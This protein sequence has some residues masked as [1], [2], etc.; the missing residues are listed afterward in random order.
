MWRWIRSDCWDLPS[1]VSAPCC[2][3][4]TF[5]DPAGWFAHDSVFGGSGGYVA[6]RV[7]ALLDALK[8]ILGIAG[9]PGEWNLANGVTVLAGSDSGNLRPAYR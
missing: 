4:R 1:E 7:V 9:N 8:P 5:H 2:F 6:P 3:P